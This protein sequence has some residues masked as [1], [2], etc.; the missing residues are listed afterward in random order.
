[1]QMVMAISE[2]IVVLNFGRKI[3]DGLP[4]AVRNDPDVIEAYLGSRKQL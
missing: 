1:M 3:A 2:H 4:D